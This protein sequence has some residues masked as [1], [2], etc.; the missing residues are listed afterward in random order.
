[1]RVKP[2]LTD[3]GTTIMSHD[4]PVSEISLSLDDALSLDEALARWDA[5]R[6]PG[7]LLRRAHQRSHDLYTERVGRDGPTRQQIAVLIAL[8]QKPGASQAD[9]AAASGIDRNTLAEMLGRL[10]ERGLVR[11]RRADGDG[12]AWQLQLSEAGEALLVAT[13][14]KA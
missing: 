6:E 13:M 8:H 11:R 7:P 3:R 2:A 10:I 9:V 12:R 1:M 14:P 4:A 5:A